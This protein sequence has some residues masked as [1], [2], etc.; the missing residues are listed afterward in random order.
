MCGPIQ[1]NSR[2]AKAHFLSL[3]TV[4]K[5][6]SL[7]KLKSGFDSVCIR[8]L[9]PF[10]LYRAQWREGFKNYFTIKLMWN[11]SKF[12]NFWKIFWTDFLTDFLDRI[13]ERF[14]DDFFYRFFWKIFWQ[15]FWQIFMTDFL[16]DFLADFYDRFF[17]SFGG[18]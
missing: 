12:P 9:Y 15:I 18:N 10:S 11:S 14:F 17:D 16:T 6:R 2:Y 4:H 5:N 7:C 3:G 1:R 8:I 13:F